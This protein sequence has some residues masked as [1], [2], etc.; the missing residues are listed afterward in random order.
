MEGLLAPF[1]TAIKEQALDQLRIEFRT[2][3][4]ALKAAVRRQNADLNLV[5]RVVQLEAQLKASQV[6]Q[7]KLKD[8]IRSTQADQA[9]LKGIFATSERLATS[10]NAAFRQLFQGCLDLF[11][12]SLPAEEYAYL[13]HFHCQRQPANLSR[14]S[15]RN[16]RPTNATSSQLQLR[17]LIQRSAATPGE[18]PRNTQSSSATLGRASS[19]PLNQGGVQPNEQPVSPS[20]QQRTQRIIAKTTPKQKRKTSDLED[21]LEDIQVSQRP[22][23]KVQ[24][25]SQVPPSPQQMLAVKSQAHLEVSSPASDVSIRSPERKRKDLLNQFM[26]PGNKKPAER[27]AAKAK[28][29]EESLSD[30]EPIIPL[31]RDRKRRNFDGSVEWKDVPQSALRQKM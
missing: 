26:N 17:T 3:I 10:T 11:S 7:A 2:E 27:T 12:D 31:K 15:S 30:E 1:V 21:D 29:D 4:D 14:S 8:Q 25:N 23:K 9:L 5:E 20:P 6:D 16:D 13:H 18:V 28:D 22:K 19:A 24:F